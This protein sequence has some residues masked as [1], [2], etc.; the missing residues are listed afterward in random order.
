MNPSRNHA[1]VVMAVCAAAGLAFGA[2]SALSSPKEAP[3]DLPREAAAGEEDRDTIVDRL[4]TLERKLERARANPTAAASP[5][6]APTE[7]ANTEE[8]AADEGANPEMA[9]KSRQEWVKD[10][11]GSYEATYTGQPEDP[12]WSARTSRAITE[13][14]RHTNIEGS[15]VNAASCRSTMCRVEMSHADQA[16]QAYFVQHIPRE[17]PFDTSGFYHRVETED[18]ASS[19]VLYLARTGFELPPPPAR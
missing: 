16:A 18:G 10:V 4:T 14:L 19:T 12:D 1:I 9:P 2:G 6:P 8:A 7:P 17:P 3:P 15:T 11:I 5:A 13:T